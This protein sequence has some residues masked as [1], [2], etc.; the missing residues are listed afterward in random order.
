M[1]LTN[2]SFVN[3]KDLSSQIKYVICLA[4]ATNKVNVIHWSSIKCER[5]TRFVLIAKLYVITHEFDIDAIIKTIMSK[6][7][8]ITVFL[9]LCIDFKSLYDCLI[10]LSTTREKR[11][12]INVMSFRQ[13]YERREII[14]VKWIHEHNNS[15]D[16]MIKTKSSFALKTIIKTNQINLNIIQWMKRETT[17][18]TIDATDAL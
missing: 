5:V 12:I 16:S 1:I 11:L 6:M 15:I 3:N 4:N 17:N 9:V 7:L 13:S 18:V 8:S 10:K 2:V 14:E